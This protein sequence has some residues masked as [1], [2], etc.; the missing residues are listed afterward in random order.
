MVEVEISV[1]GAAGAGALA[2]WLRRDPGVVRS[3]VEIAPA[4]RPRPQVPTGAMGTVDTVTALVDST[5]GLVSLLVCVAAWRRP[6]GT[7]PP[8]VRVVERDG[9]VLEG[10]ADDVLVVLRARREQSRTQVRNT[11]PGQA[12][13]QGGV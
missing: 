11:E 5:V 10:T 2:G 1:G 9:T 7:P 8:S 6:V 13:E 3:G 4:A 12:P